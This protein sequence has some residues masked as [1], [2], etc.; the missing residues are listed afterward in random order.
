[1]TLDSTNTASSCKGTLDTSILAIGLV[2][3]NLAT[4]ITLSSHFL[5]FITFGSFVTFS[6]TVV[7]DESTGIG[8]AIAVIDSIETIHIVISRVVT[9]TCFS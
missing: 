9:T 8:M 2:V 6:T 1:M 4:I 5:W 7:A 3:T